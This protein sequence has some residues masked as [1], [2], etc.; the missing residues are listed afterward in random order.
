MEDTPELHAEI[1]T[2]LPLVVLAG[3]DAA[4]GAMPARGAALHPLR[5]VKGYDVEIDGEHLVDLAVERFSRCPSFAPVYVAG[6]ASVYGHERSGAQVMDTSGSFGENIRAALEQV[7]SLHPGS[8]IAFAAC[9]VLPRRAELA[10]LMED[11]HRR[12]PIDFWFP[13]IQAPEEEGQLGTSAWKPRYGIAQSDEVAPKST[14][15]GHLLVVDPQAL[16]L[17]FV[18]RAF[19][20]AYRSRNR[21]VLPRTAYI[22]WKVLSYLIGQDLRRIARLAL[23]SVTLTVLVHAAMLGN[24][25]SRGDISEAELAY[26]LNGIFVKADHV[27]DHPE[28]RGLIHVMTGLSLAK[29]VDTQE[30]AAEL[31]GELRRLR[32]EERET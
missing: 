18:Y 32:A 14:L 12:A 2:S 13:I 26:R 15:P 16:H 22:F 4:P 10:E 21:P 5:G 3:G 31:V 23:P 1:P 30:E 7:T 24:H 8:P 11:Y 6:P 27:K 25:L 9:D 20:A 28:R 19:D 17:D 29:D